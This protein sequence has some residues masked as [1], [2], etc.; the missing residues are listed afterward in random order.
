MGK[1][2]LGRSKQSEC[3]RASVPKYWKH[4]GNPVIDVTN[5]EPH[6]DI[7][8]SELDGDRSCGLGLSKESMVKDSAATGLKRVP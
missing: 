6:L 4:F 8:R 2:S 1:Q 3:P 7:L 5:A